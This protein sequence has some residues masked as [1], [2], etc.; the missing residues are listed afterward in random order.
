MRYK[1]S[2]SR[3]RVRRLSVRIGDIIHAAGVRFG[4]PSSAPRR[5]RVN[6]VYFVGMKRLPG[7]TVLFFAVT[8]AC[9]AQRAAPDAREAVMSFLAAFS[10]GDAARFMPYFAEDATMFFPPGPASDGPMDRIQGR[11]NIERIFRTVFGRSRIGSP[12][13]RTTPLSPQDLLVQQFDGWAVAT[14][15]LGDN[16]R[17]RRTVVLKQSGAAWQIVHLHASASTGPPH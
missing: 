7:P 3:R 10:S 16:P 4:F 14:F 1:E 5:A 17:Q 2:S 6:E 15:H 11:A 9:F 12:A 8:V 13:A